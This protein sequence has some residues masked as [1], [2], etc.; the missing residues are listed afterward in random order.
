MNKIN[1][2]ENLKQNFDSFPQEITKSPY[3]RPNSSNIF[4]NSHLKMPINTNLGK[5]VFPTQNN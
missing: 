4:K 3:Y 1:E 2:K 5:N